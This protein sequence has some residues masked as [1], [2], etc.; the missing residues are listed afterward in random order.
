MRKMGLD[1]GDKRIGIAVSDPLN[2]T[3]QAR[4]VLERSQHHRELEVFK[5]YITEY[6][7]TEII[8]GLPKNM[9]N[10]CGHQAKKVKEYV[11][12]LK[13]NLDIPIIFWDE[14]LSSREA[15]KL[16]IKAD[17][18]RS[19]RKDVIDKVAAAII[20]QGYLNFEKNKKTGG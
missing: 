17:L 6:Q 16:L 8:V 1:I 12:F 14:R 9:D 20:L 18:R 7:I 19:H 15:Q 2:C 13:N 4:E 5:K 10:S 3:A 11:N